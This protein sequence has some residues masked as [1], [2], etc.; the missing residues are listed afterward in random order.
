MK[1]IILSALLLYCNI[2]HSQTSN[3]LS[4]GPFEL[5]ERINS[6]VGSSGIGRTSCIRFDPDYITNQILYL[7]TPLGGLWKFDPTIGNHWINM[8]TDNLPNIG[9]SDVVVDPTNRQRIYLVT[10]DPDTYLNPYYTYLGSTAEQS[11]GIYLST[12]GGNSWSNTPLGNWY[13]DDPN[14]VIN[15]FWDFPS[16]KKMRR[17]ISNPS[18]SMELFTL[19][20]SFDRISN[21]PISY[22]YHTINQGLDWYRNSTFSNE[23]LCDIEFCPG[24][25]NIIYI[26]GKSVYK[27]TNGG[28]VWTNLNTNGLNSTGL[29][30]RSE[31]SVSAANPN[32]IYCLQAI[33]GYDNEF[34]VSDDKGGTFSIICQFSG[35]PFLRTSLA[36]D[37]TN[38]NNVYATSNNYIKKLTYSSGSWSTSGYLPIPHADVHEIAFEPNSNIVFVSTDGGIAKSIDN[39]NSWTYICDGLCITQLWS[40]ATD[41][42]DPDFISI[43][44]QDNGT[45][46]HGA[47]FNNNVDN[48]VKAHDGDGHETMIDE[49][50]NRFIF[51]S[52]AQGTGFLS[53]SS[54]FG[55]NW[56]GDIKPI[57]ASS[58]DSQFPIVQ[59]PVHPNIIYVGFENLYKS[60]DFGLTWTQLTNINTNRKIKNISICP[61]KPDH[62]YISYSYTI[63][64]PNPLIGMLWYS[65][66]GGSTWFDRTNGLDGASGGII[67][68][69]ATDPYFPSIVYVSFRGTSHLMMKSIDAGLTWTDF[70]N[71]LP[72]D[73]DYYNLISELGSKNLYVSA[74][75]GVYLYNDDIGT[76]IPYKTNLPNVWVLENKINYTSNEI[77]SATH[78]R[79]T[80]KSNLACPLFTNLNLNGNVASNKL[81]ECQGTL[82]S[83][84]SII[85]NSE[86]IYRS[87]DEVTLLPGFSTEF[88]VAFEALIHG[89]VSEG[90]SFRMGTNISN[91]PVATSGN[92]F[93]ELPEIILVPNPS[94]D[95]VNIKIKSSDEFSKYPFYIYNDYGQLLSVGILSSESM[96]IDVS[97]FKIGIYII[98]TF[99]NDRK[100]INKLVKI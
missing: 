29:V 60:L 28:V 94:K 1:Y 74:S 56:T 6:N 40:V 65:S 5:P 87:T 46:L 7:G 68:G 89:C 85:S 63:W 70:M 15:N 97:E 62:I 24:N 53:R 20:E 71:G 86:V 47:M 27:S 91:S 59:D 12:D 14:V 100:Y 78:G 8:N 17:L 22:V 32:I 36:I 73:A 64:Y 19:V 38:E 30:E 96:S 16:Q 9:I 69:I 92:E 77:F 44:T 75:N 34:Y 95:V 39:G 61:T 18:N 55:Y 57:G 52:D 50:E 93:N 25:A 58:D 3:W 35:S 11:R 84:E 88:G 80:W 10:G 98:E 81:S 26:S 82:T 99:I 2:A 42:Q 72:S 49:S 21:S 83:S 79:G 43:G 66:D 33:P 4:L 31:I 76:W 51:H 54:N 67:S 23:R 37:P 13:G 48:W 90:N 45:N 41:K